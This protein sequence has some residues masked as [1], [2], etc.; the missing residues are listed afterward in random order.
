IAHAGLDA[1]DIDMIIGASITPQ[2]G[3]P[4]TAVFVQRE[5]Q[6][7]DTAAPCFDVNATCLSFLFALQTAAHFVNSGTRRNVL[8]FSSEIHSISMNP[9]QPE[10]AVLFGDGAAAVVVSPASPGDEARIW[11]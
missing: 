11:D 1:S 2:Q 4:C 10:S 9:K 5:L 3:V 6:M 7:F 8:I